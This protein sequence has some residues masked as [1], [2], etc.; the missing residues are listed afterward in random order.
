MVWLTE[1]E[2]EEEK[3]IPSKKKKKKKKHCFRKETG[4]GNAGSFSLWS[5]A[6]LAFDALCSQSPVSIHL[7]RAFDFVLKKTPVCNENDVVVWCT[8]SELNS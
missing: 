3:V 2:I 5:L 4:R 1:S 7:T 8:R 6:T